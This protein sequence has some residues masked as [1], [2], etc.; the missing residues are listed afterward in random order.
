MWV[1]CGPPNRVDL[2]SQIKAAAVR[3]VMLLNHFGI[4]AAFNWIC[5]NISG[6]CRGGSFEAR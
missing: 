4:R 5:M 2:A 6:A 3:Y 1:K